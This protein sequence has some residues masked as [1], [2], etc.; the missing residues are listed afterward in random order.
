V[1]STRPKIDRGFTLVELLVVIGIIAVLIAILLPTINRARKMAN[2]TACL[3]NIKQLNGAWQ[4]YSSQNKGILFPFVWQYGV[5]NLPANTQPSPNAFDWH[6]SWLG[7]VT[8]YGSISLGALVCPEARDPILGDIDS[9]PATNHGA[10]FGTANN[11][12]SGLF[13]KDDSTYATGGN[14][15][16]YDSTPTAVCNQ[17]N[18][19]A[20]GYRIGTYGYNAY[21][22]AGSADTANAVTGTTTFDIPGSFGGS[23]GGIPDSGN[24]PTFCDS[25]AFWVKPEPY[26]GPPGSGAGAYTV[27]ANMKLSGQSWTTDHLESEKIMLNRHPT[28]SINIGF[29][30]GSARTVSVDDLYT[31]QWASSNT[32]TT[33]AAAGPWVKFHITGLP[34]N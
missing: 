24:T 2:T 12:W 19:V 10:G 18:P 23:L 13:Q 32:A 34:T 4:L 25:I 16:M 20:G 26:T 28:R 8:D 14:G 9:A 3:A 1:N 29:A 31:L 6:N 11:A 7:I 21:L 5:K 30:D 15:V 33:L 17:S 22:F 27:P